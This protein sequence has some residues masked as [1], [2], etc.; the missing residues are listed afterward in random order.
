[1]KG[2]GEGCGG[3]GEWYGE[4]NERGRCGGAGVDY[5]GAR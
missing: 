4:V 1:M 3:A 5:E 2:A